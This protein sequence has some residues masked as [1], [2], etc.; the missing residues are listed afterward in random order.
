[1]S[2]AIISGVT[3]LIIVDDASQTHACTR[4][5]Y[6]MCTNCNYQSL[7]LRW[8][9]REHGCERLFSMYE[10]T[11]DIV[12][13]HKDCSSRFSDK[14]GPHAKRSHG[15][16]RISVIHTSFRAHGNTHGSGPVNSARR[17]HLIMRHKSRSGRLAAERESDLSKSRVFK[18]CIWRTSNSNFS[19]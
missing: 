11:L 5:L 2:A 3:E 16:S 1:M 8:C 9:V 12:R 13:T 15:V 6:G 4:E 14:L 18:S 19:N 7:R 10:N 17:F